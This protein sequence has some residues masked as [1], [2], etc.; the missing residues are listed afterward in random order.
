MF[1]G[2]DSPLGPPPGGA[3]EDTILAVES[4]DIP[5]ADK[6]KIFRDNA[7]ELFQYSV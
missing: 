1:F 5:E 4:M 3:V 6:K 7:I 2:T